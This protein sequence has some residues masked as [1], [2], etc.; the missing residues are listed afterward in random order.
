MLISL[1]SG[2][3]VLGKE[4]SKWLAVILVGCDTWNEIRCAAI[5]CASYLCF[6]VVFWL[7]VLFVVGSITQLKLTSSQS[8]FDLAST[9]NYLEILGFMSPKSFALQGL[10]ATQTDTSVHA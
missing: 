3:S 5:V 4:K 9:Q 7:F 2:L 10:R 8:V 6:F 1:R